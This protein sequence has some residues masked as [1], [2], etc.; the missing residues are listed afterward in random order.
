M[1]LGAIFMVSL[2]VSQL[3]N[4]QRKAREHQIRVSLLGNLHFKGKVI[5]SKNYRYYGKIYYQV[6]VKLDSVN[7]KNFYV[8]ND[9]DCLRIK[10]SIATFS[11]GYLNHTLGVADSVEAN[12]KNSGKLVLYYRG[13]AKDSAPLGFDPKGLHEDDL[14][15]CE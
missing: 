15:N 9:L 7:V 1:A 3:F 6:C 5:S 14:K 2:V 4:A 13:H 10:D 12:M 8:Y 11:A